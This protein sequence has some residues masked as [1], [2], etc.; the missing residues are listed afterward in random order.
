M[1][2]QSRDKNEQNK[3]SNKQI[4][5]IKQTIVSLSVKKFDREKSDVLIRD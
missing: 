1:N 3:S 2:G 4:S 5:I